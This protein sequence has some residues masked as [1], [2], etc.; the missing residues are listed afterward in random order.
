[1]HERD[2]DIPASTDKGLVISMAAAVALLAFIIIRAER[3]IIV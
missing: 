1:M 2:T 3:K